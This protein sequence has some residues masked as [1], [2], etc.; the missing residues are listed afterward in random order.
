MFLFPLLYVN[1]FK[2]IF[3][4]L[5]FY[6]YDRNKLLYLDQKLIY[7]VYVYYRAN[8]NKIYIDTNEIQLKKK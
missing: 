2:I 8:Y 5:F 6:P 1:N 7:Y 4:D 3:N